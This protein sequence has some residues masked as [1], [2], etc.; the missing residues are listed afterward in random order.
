[1]LFWTNT[2]LPKIWSTFSYFQSVVLSKFR[3]NYYLDIAQAVMERPGVGNSTD[4][5][6]YCNM[7][8]LQVPRYERN[9]HDWVE[10]AEAA[11]IIAAP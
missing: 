8:K 5:N 1:M 2:I 6:Y 11:A 10:N 4:L 7:E 9:E 3:I